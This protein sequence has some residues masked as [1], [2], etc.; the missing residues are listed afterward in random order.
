MRN[1]YYISYNLIAKP[2]TELIPP[3]SNFLS[4]TQYLLN[5]QPELHLPQPPYP[6]LS[7]TTSSKSSVSPHPSPISPPQPTTPSSSSRHPYTSSP[8][9]LYRPIPP[10]PQSHPL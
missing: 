7:S 3:P 5:I 4:Q 1:C 9:Y 8:H 2:G 10:D 6:L